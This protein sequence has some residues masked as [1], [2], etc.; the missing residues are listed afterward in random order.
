MGTVLSRFTCLIVVLG[1]LWLASHGPSPEEIRILPPGPALAPR[2]A[3][4]SGVWETSTA[5]AS[6]QVVVEYINETW[7]SVVH[8]WGA[9]SWKREHAMVFRDGVVRWGSPVRYAL[10]L[11]PEGAVL[12]TEGVGQREEH[13]LRR[14]GVLSPVVTTVADVRSG[15]VGGVALR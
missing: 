6:R 9:D 8:V 11:T 12:E 7:A 3:G 14:V 2:V 13:P 5:A 4:L 1:V 10:K 15:V